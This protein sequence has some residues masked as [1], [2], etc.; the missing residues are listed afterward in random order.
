M[1][2]LNR[3]SEFSC[4]EISSL[5]IIGINKNCLYAIDKLANHLDKKG[6]TKEADYLDAIISKFSQEQDHQDS[7]E[8]DEG[9]TSNEKTVGES[10]VEKLNEANGQQQNE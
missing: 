9:M 10:A 2:F 6:F 1:C 3:G 5:C 4:I 8:S 7:N